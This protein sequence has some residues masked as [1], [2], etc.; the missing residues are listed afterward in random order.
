MEGYEINVAK[1]IARKI[2]DWDVSTNT[3]HAFPCLLMQICLKEVLPKIAGVD[4]FKMVHK[5]QIWV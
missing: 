5:P 4:Y 1:I 3:I 2:C